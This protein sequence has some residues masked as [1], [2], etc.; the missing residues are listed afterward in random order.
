MHFDTYGFGAGL[1]ATADL[2]RRAE[3]VGFDT[4]WF[5]EAGHNPY[6]PCAVSTEAAPA[7]GVGTSIAATAVSMVPWPENIM[8]GRSG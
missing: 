3:N 1:S 5:T 7:M 4:M 6:L 2:A 8:T